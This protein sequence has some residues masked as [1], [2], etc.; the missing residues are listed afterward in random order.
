MLLDSLQMHL[1][2]LREGVLTREFLLLIPLLNQL[3][4]IRLDIPHDILQLYF[5]PRE[6]DL[7][8]VLSNYLVELPQDLWCRRE[9]QTDMCCVVDLLGNVDEGVTPELGGFVGTGGDLVDKG[10][11]GCVLLG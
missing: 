4:H 9:S 6:L 5:V 3:L 7:F 11:V 2:Q 10:E 1:P 8:V